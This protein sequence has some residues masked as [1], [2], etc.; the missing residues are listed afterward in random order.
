MGDGSQGDRPVDGEAARKKAWD[1]AS[2][3][4]SN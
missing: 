2:R 1:Q 4:S 3:N